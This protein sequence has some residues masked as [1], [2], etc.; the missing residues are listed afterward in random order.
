MR[1]EAAYHSV[2]ETKGM[3]K[4]LEIF[5]RAIV[6]DTA[7]LICDWLKGN[8]LKTT[9]DVQTLQLNEIVKHIE[10]GNLVLAEEKLKFHLFDNQSC[11]K[12][13]MAAA[14]ICLRNNNISQAME[15]L[16]SVYLREPSNTTALYA[17]GYC[18]ERLGR[19]DEAVAFYQDCLKFKY[20]LQLPR[21]R[22]A[23]IYFSRNQLDKTV[24][25]YES[26]IREY[27]DD[28]S[29]LVILGHLYMANL[30]YNL[31]IET[32][33]NAILIH[34]DN[35]LPEPE[36]AKIIMLVRS[37]N[38]LEAADE[39]QW[40]LEQQGDNSNLNVKLADILSMLG[41]DYQAISH[42]E[43]AFEAQ[44]QC[45]E[46]AIKLGIH[47]LRLGQFADAAEYFTK[48]NE[49]NDQIVEAY[50]GLAIA[51]NLAG[52]IDDS[53]GTLSLASTIQQNSTL[54]FGQA[55]TIQ[56][57]AVFEN[58]CHNENTNAFYGIETVIKAHAIQIS[59]HP[60][61][62]DINY[63]YG[64]LLMGT[65]DLLQAESAFKK[66]L[67]INP[68]YH[69]ARYMLSLCIC[70][71][72]GPCSAFSVFSEENHLPPKNILQLHYKTA[73]LYS[74]KTK[75]TRALQNLQRSFDLNFTDYDAYRNIASVLQNLG[76]MDRSL[77]TVQYLTDIANQV[78]SIS[79]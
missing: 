64:L 19:L 1:C 68:T 41:E 39:I 11:V 77:A 12:G 42:Y 79:P 51:Q 59:H 69:R 47:H 63:R 36:D 18:N 56:F 71:T 67:E 13:R 22:V 31:A 9:N 61:N 73:I 26:L 25:E 37:G 27:P 30:K 57:K 44:P 38:L 24:H 43:R 75:F 17:L 70:E 53:Y 4:L 23:A 28:I 48:A 49:I 33:N 54:L 74:D 3:S 32:F 40:R 20:Y 60:Y 15:S 45:L 50:I 14:A 65:G 16:Q 8:T 78:F 6:V 21:L 46:A 52:K 7:D 34:P 29:S 5:G 62:A 35:F 76:L 10:D 2:H 58:L 72:E 66:V 55:A